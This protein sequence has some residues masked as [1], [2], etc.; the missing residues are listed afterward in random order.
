MPVVVVVWQTIGTNREVIAVVRP[1]GLSRNIET[2]IEDSE[3]KRLVATAGIVTAMLPS[4]RAVIGVV[5][6]DGPL[7]V[8]LRI[9]QPGPDQDLML[10]GSSKRAV[11]FTADMVGCMPTGHLGRQK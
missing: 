3:S 5:R 7:V 1:F 2:A 10:G 9:Q 8:T 4:K 11:Y 6:A